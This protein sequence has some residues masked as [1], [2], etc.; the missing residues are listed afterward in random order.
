MNFRTIIAVLF[1][2][3]PVFATL[4]VVDGVGGGGKYATLSAAVAAANAGDSIF[5]QPGTYT[6]SQAVAVSKRLIIFGN[7]YKNPIASTV[8]QYQIQLTAGATGSVIQHLKFESTTIGISIQGINDCN[9]SDSYFDNAQIYLNG[10]SND[11]VINNIIISKNNSYNMVYMDGTS[12]GNV[13]ANN[14]FDGAVGGTTYGIGSNGSIARISCFNNYFGDLTYPINPSQGNGAYIIVGNIFVKTA[15][16]SSSASNAVVYSGNWLY[17]VQNNPTEPANGEANITGDPQFE[18]FSLT[19]GFVFSGDTATDSDLRIKST[20]TPSPNSPIDGSY[21]AVAPVGSGYVDVLQQPG[22]VN[23]NRSDAGI[24]GGPL[25]FAS[26][27]TPSTIPSPSSISITPA[28]IRPKGMM[29]ISVTGGFGTG[30]T[31]APQ[32]RPG[33]E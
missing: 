13:I 32:R 29:K 15:T 1:L 12:A 10:S 3:V 8:L 24:F 17:S 19:N 2:A 6:E 25:P 7:G 26:L 18:R 20:A 4:R 11:T 30:A 16:I 9:V 5:I 31:P 21:P 27:Y 22:T 23:T 28:G 14:I 33:G